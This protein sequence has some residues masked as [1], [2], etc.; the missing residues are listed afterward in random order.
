MAETWQ[1]L[2]CETFN[3]PSE[4]ECKA[5]HGRRPGATTASTPR[6]PAPA[7]SG[8]TATLAPWTCPGCRTANASLAVSCD[9]CRTPRPGSTDWRDRGTR[10]ARTA[11]ERPR[12]PAAAPDVPV[13]PSRPPSSGPRLVGSLWRGSG[14]ESS[15]PHFT[16]H[17]STPRGAYTSTYAVPSPKAPAKPTPRPPAASRPP[18][19][20]P[21][22][23]T[24]PAPEPRWEPP[25]R[26]RPHRGRGSRRV[27]TI[28]SL[29]AI[30]AAI[31]YTR[32]SWEPDLHKLTSPAPDSTAAQSAST[33]AA[34]PA[35]VAAT[36]PDGSGSTLIAAYDTSEFVVT[37]CRT[38]TGVIYYHGRNKKDTS[39]Q[40]TL[41]A[42]E[43]NGAYRAVNSGYTYLVTNKDLIVAHDGTTLL[44]QR[45]TPAR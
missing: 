2:R 21:P 14:D 45:L 39:Q 4:P 22:P 25:P 13:A 18:A 36:I 10:P 20:S 23:P 6:R 3:A 44:D 17:A 24:P 26:Y 27:L 5:C 40:I 28:L 15:T 30:A 34:C 32:S 7:T 42:T 43:V 16:P 38:S 33:G 9:K 31:F 1:C 12:A 11:P 35:D 37:L 8:T 41:L 29:L 19:V